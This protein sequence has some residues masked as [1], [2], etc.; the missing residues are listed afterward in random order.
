MIRK[1]WLAFPLVV[2]CLSQCVRATTVTT[3]SCSLSDVQNA[4]NSASTGD[5]VLT[6]GPCSV[7][8]STA[9]TIPSTLG[10]TINGGGNTTLTNWGFSINQNSSASTRI[11]G[12]TFT[13]SMPA[14]NQGPITVNGST[15]SNMG[16][17][18]HN[19][20]NDQTD[21]GT[22]IWL[23][24]N[25]PMLIDHDTFT[26]CAA[27]EMIHNMAAGAGD[28]SGWVD[29]VTPGSPNMVFIETNTFT[30]N[31]SGNPAYDYGTAAVQSY[32]G[33][34]TVVRYNS[35]Y[36]VHIDQHGTAGMVGARWWEI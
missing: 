30:Y 32:Y 14:A 31:A 16:R 8:W 20:F 13:N 17:I 23:Y 21:N 22:F 29:N 4:V 15:S 27:C 25:G 26:A 5:T 1:E 6:P 10:I 12:F 19:T 36:M 18:D 7:S 35:L 9:V 2:F 3:A 28:N 33:A 11:T 24:G 34:R